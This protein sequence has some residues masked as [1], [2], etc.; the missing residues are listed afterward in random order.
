MQRRELLRH[1]A[2]LTGCAFVGVDEAFALKLPPPPNLFIETHVALLDEIAETILP[3]TDAPGAKDAQVGAFVA[4]YST[5]CYDEAQRARVRA[6]LAA[7]DAQSQTEFGVDFVHASREQRESLLVRIDAQAKRET[8]E[9]PD[10]PPHY[11]I[12][13]KQLTLLGFFTSEAGATKVARHRPIPGPYKGIVP[14]KKGET[15]WS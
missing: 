11:F 2:A 7:I 10:Q 13:L 1:I 12:L 5:A 14:Y 15:F 9:H 4:R 8:K 6:G 3:R